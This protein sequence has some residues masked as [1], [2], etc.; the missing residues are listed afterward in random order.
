M[1][2]QA[3]LLGDAAHAVVPFFGQGMNASFQDC[4]LLRKLIDKHS[5]DWAVIFSEFSRIH[6]KNGHSI[7]K[8][9]IENYLEMR[10]HVNDP[11]YRKRRKLELKMERMF[12]GEFIPRYSMVSFHQIPYSEVY[13]RGEKQL[14]IIEAMLEKFDDISEIDE[15]AVQD[16]LQIPTD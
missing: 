3:L 8:M 1:G 9:A 6:V 10:D 13:T 5:G 11:T 16:Y 2:S 15:I 4:S 14:K 12:P 7:A